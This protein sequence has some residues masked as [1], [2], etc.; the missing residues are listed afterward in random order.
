MSKH[1][2]HDAPMT[3]YEECFCG[4]CREFGKFDDLCEEECNS[5]ETCFC[6]SDKRVNEE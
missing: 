2:L 1:C 4:K 6:R 3:T 5:E